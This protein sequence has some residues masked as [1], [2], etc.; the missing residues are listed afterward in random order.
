VVQVILHELIE[1]LKTCFDELEEA[2]HEVVLNLIWKIYFEEEVEDKQVIGQN[3]RKS[4][5]V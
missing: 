3:K 1:D 4:Q 2:L 5:K